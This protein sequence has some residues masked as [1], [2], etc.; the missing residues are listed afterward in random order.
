MRF[1]DRVRET[2]TTTGTGSLTLSGTAAAGYERFQDAYAVNET[3]PYCIQDTANNA[4]EVGLGVLSG[5][6][7]LTR[8]IVISS[9]N[10]DAL[11]NFS[12]GTKDVFI[13]VPSQ[14]ITSFGQSYA[15]ARGIY[16]P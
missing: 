12:A 14:M 9:S 7:T 1:A 15:M 2:T 10:S 11:V 16:L 13:P 5:T 3:V 4:F 8:D 6:T